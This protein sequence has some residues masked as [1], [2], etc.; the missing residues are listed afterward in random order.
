[1]VVVAGDMEADFGGLWWSGLGYIGR[2]GVC[3]DCDYRLSIRGEA[4]SATGLLVCRCCGRR[5]IAST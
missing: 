5:A 4:S 1:M 3:Q 2:N